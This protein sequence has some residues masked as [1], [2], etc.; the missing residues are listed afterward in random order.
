MGPDLRAGPA[1]R[2]PGFDTNLVCYY[3]RGIMQVKIVKDLK[4]QIIF[5]NYLGPLFN[6]FPKSFRPSLFHWFDQIT[7][8]L[9][10]DYDKTTKDAVDFC[11]GLGCWP[12]G[13]RYY[14]TNAPNADWD[15]FDL[16][17]EEL[18]AK[19]LADGWVYSPPQESVP[20]AVCFF[21]KPGANVQIQ[22]VENLKVQIMLRN[23]LKYWLTVFPK[24]HRYMA[25]W[26]FYTI[27]QQT[28]LSEPEFY[29]EP[30]NSDK[31][32]IYSD[33]DFWKN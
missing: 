4:K 15:F 13:S 8:L 30:Q 32:L 23:C 25:I 24:S 5:K 19:F 16:Y 14:G 3:H 6:P 31:T 29:A 21:T 28:L 12:M 18:K 27:I 17:S 10:A 11:V 22:L 33:N 20:N 26:S 1:S 9:H 2:T 7:M